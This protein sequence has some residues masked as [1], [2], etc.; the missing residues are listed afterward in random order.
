MDSTVIPGPV[1]LEEHALRVIITRE[2]WGDYFLLTL[3]DNTSYEL[4][5]E[6]T[7]EWFRKRGAKMDV[8]ESELD[9]AWNFYV[10]VVDIYNFRE[11][12]DERL[13]HSPKV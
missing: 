8:I 7:R 13:P 12:L 4:E 11:P 2:P 10:A 9:T 5:P 1:G 3:P 6:E